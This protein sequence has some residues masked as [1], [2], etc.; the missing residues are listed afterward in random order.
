MPPA[1]RIRRTAD[2]E[3]IKRLD[4]TCFGDEDSLAEVLGC[5]DWWVAESRAGSSWAPAGYAG[6]SLSDG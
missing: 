6:A 3:L 1:I 4:K 2:L 5:S